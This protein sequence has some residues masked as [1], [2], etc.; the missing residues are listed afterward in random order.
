[1]EETAS[2]LATAVQHGKA[3]YVGISFYSAGKTPEISALLR[4]WKVSWLIHQP[5]YN[6]LNRWIKGSLRGEDTKRNLKHVGYL[7]SLVKARRKLLT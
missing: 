5:S 4:E 7:F 6:L 3:L 2:A 1:L